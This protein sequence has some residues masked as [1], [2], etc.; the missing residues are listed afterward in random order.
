MYTFFSLLGDSAFGQIAPLEHT[1]NGIARKSWSLV[2]DVFHFFFKYIKQ[3]LVL[4]PHCGK[5]REK[6][7]WGVLNRLV[8]LFPFFLLSF[9]FL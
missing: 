6:K 2:F 3:K 7:K 4:F 1:E 9:S 8:L 5:G